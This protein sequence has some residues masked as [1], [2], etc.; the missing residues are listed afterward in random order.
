MFDVV[1]TGT[2]RIYGSANTRA[3]AEKLRKKIAEGDYISPSYFEI[4]GPVCRLCGKA[5]PCG[6]KRAQ[7]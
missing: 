7:P 4:V 5:C 3:G 1:G 2:R 6:K